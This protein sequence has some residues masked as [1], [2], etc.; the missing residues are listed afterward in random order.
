MAVF[1]AKTLVL[2]PQNEQMGSFFH[3]MAMLWADLAH[4]CTQIH[5]VSIIFTNLD[6]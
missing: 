4:F 2:L 3:S 1:S 6:S 5:F